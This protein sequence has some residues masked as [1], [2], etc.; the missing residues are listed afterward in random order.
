MMY[1]RFALIGFLFG[2]VLMKS[3]AVSW[4]RIQEMFRTLRTRLNGSQ[5]THSTRP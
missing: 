5:T 1:L 2:T 4:F 3:E